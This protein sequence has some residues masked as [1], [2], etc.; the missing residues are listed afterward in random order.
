[1]SYVIDSM[2]EQLQKAHDSAVCIHCGGTAT[3][4]SND[5]SVTEYH[6]SGLCQSCQNE[7]FD[8]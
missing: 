4:F 5:I 6:Q 7:V 3:D 2:Q 8:V 1:M